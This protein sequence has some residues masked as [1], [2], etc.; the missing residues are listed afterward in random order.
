M[1]AR[2]GSCAY[3]IGPPIRQTY[4]YEEGLFLGDTL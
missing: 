4:T 1:G 3:R 2:S